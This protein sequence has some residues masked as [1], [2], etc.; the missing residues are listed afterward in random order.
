ML[1]NPVSGE[2]GVAHYVPFIIEDYVDNP[3]ALARLKA[4]LSQSALARRMDVTQA[5]I[6]KIERKEKVSAKVFQKVQRAL[7]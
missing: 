7:K 4:G 3:V 2:R 1:L 6:S 5:Y